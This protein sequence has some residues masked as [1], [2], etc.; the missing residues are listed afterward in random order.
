[1]Q[2]KSPIAVT[3]LTLLTL[4]FFLRAQSAPA[5]TES[6]LY[7]FGV[8]GSPSEPSA[9]MIF[10]SSGNLYGTSAYGGE[11]GLGSVF[12]LMPVVGGG[13]TEI[14][15]HSFTNNGTDGLLPYGSLIFDSA[16]NLY[17]T[18]ELGGTGAC[19]F[20][21][22]GCGT[23]FKL[24]PAGGGEWTETVLYSF[25]GNGMDGQEPLA[26]LTFDTTG[27]LYGTTSQ[28]GLGAVGTVF[29]LSPQSDGAWKESVVRSFRGNDGQYPQGTLIFD[30]LGNLYG[31]TSSG[32]PYRTGTIFELSPQSGDSWTMQTLYIFDVLSRHGKYPVS[33]LV[34]DSVGN[35]YGTTEYGGQFG[36][37]TIFEL[38][39]GESGKWTQKVL[40]SFADGQ[41]TDGEFPLAGPVLDS[42]GNLYGATTSGGSGVCNNS[43]YPGCGT[44][45]E[46]VPKGNGQWTERVLHNFTGYPA[47]GEAPVGS[48]VLSVRGNVLGT[49]VSGGSDYLGSAF[50][51]KP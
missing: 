36:G 48:V 29:E 5:Q 39:P 33:G 26:A 21:Y 10:D 31:T 25:L 13:Y 4:I 3:V 20:D 30:S 2:G 9:G 11:G 6:V 34:F 16:G 35:L 22:P 28:G 32:G 23:V 19:S 46:L 24:T 49:T 41:G 38:M 15:L 18:T 14:L 50:E 47:D 17:G 27:N 42:K 51:I 1:M 45:F 37:G 40:H 7:N 43:F 44:V 8:A 12:E